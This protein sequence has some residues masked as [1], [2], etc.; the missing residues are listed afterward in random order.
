[1]CEHLIHAAIPAH[2]MHTHKIHWF[3]IQLFLDTSEWLRLLNRY[4]KDRHTDGYDVIDTL[5]YVL[6]P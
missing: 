4:K 5:M 2:E 3:S 1:M 6:I